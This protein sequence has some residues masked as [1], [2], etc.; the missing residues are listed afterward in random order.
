MSGDQAADR[1]RRRA[2]LI[3]VRRQVEDEVFFVIADP[4]TNEHVRFGEVEHAIFDLLDGTRDLRALAEAFEARTGSTIGEDDLAEFV[5]SLRESDMVE[6]AVFDPARILEEFRMR[7]RSGRAKRQLVSGSVFLLRF[8]PFNPDRQLGW[9]ASRM[10]WCWSRSAAFFSIGLMV[11]GTALAAARWDQLLPAYTA[12]LTD[13]LAAGTGVVAGKLL[14]IYVIGGLITAIHEMAHGLTL[15]NYGG[16]VPEMGFAL[17]FFQFPGAYTDTTSSYLLPS[18]FQRVMVSLAGGYI[19]MVM[20]GA[21][22]FLW[23]A[24]VPGELLNESALIIL[25]IGGPL[26]LLFNWNPLVPY[27]G[28][29]MATDFLE[30]PNLLQNSY[31]YIGDLFREKI[32]RVSPARPRPIVRLRRTY[33]IYGTLAWLYQSTWMVLVPYFAFLL[34]SKVTGPV[35]GGLLAG[36]VTYRFAKQPAATVGRFVQGVGAEWRGR[37]ARGRLAQRLFVTGSAVVLLAVL[38]IPACP[39]HVH[40][41]AVLEPESRLEV[42]AK[43]AGFVDEFFVEE[44]TLVEAGQPL[45]RLRDPD[46]ETRLR[47]VQIRKERVRAEM[48]RHEVLGE[49]GH[50]AARRV[51]WER[52]ETE[53]RMV[54]RSHGELLI[55]SPAAGTVVGPRL[56]DRLGTRL[57]PG[58]LWCEVAVIDRLLAV[59]EILEAHLSEVADHARVTG[60]H[61]GFPGRRFPGVVSK[62]PKQGHAVSLSTVADMVEGETSQGAAYPVEVIF[63]NDEG[64]L[65]Q[66][67]TIRLRIEGPRRSLA[68]R[69]ARAA[70]RLFRGKIW[71]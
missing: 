22:V 14:L 65:R 11:A 58:A 54:A 4:R 47:E 17:A 64:L 69:M 3:V 10:R 30:A 67:M 8:L 70:L 13:T 41:D 5:E 42:R 23:W 43:V 53:H 32:F 57:E 28:Y 25:L 35:L 29:Y 44:G 16:T 15:K 27:D 12:M 52:L 7:E 48:V 40:G 37:G 20:A 56:R 59:V 33:L 39:V 38:F 71:W 55:R 1:P 49:T 24:T 50:A 31:D 66:G 9:M 21:A 18:R 61:D 60:A 34:F 51:Q 19:E 36:V 6:T 62:V 2:D 63:R 45:V 46:L 26:T 68:T